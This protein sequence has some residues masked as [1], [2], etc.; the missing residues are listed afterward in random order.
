MPAWFAAIGPIV[1]GITGIVKSASAASA[2][3]KLPDAQKY[4]ATPQMIKAEEMAERRAEQG[5]STAERAAFE[6]GMAR[7]TGAAERS[8][9]NLGLAGLGVGMSN[10]FNID[11]QNQFSAQSEAE[12][13]KGEAMYAGIAGQMQGIQDRETASFNQMLNQQRVALGQAGASG[14]KDITGAFGMAAQAANTNKLAEAY[15]NSG[16]TYGDFG[17]GVGGGGGFGGGGGGAFGDFGGGG[18]NFPGG[19]GFGGASLDSGFTGVD[20]SGFGSFGPG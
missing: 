2:A 18:G 15:A 19:L 1:Q 12:R 13:R 9:R 20:T 16:G 8:L 7:R 14:G 5:Y 6:Q 11:A 17:G 10:I 4:E 3:N